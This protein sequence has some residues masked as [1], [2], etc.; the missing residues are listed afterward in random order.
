MISKK[1]LSEVLNTNVVNI[2]TDTKKMRYNLDGSV[3]D[4]DKIIMYLDTK[5]HKINIY[6]LAHIC[7]EWAFDNK[8]VIGSIPKITESTWKKCA[9]NLTH[10]YLACKDRA[11]YKEQ[12]DGGWFTEPTEV[13]SIFKA[14]E[15][16]LN[17]RNII[18]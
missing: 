9:V 6:E 13:E 5:W 3:S 12:G 14:C 1:L 4:N 10:F 7:K 18:C 17:N 11:I 15:W 16:I 2:V 8:Y